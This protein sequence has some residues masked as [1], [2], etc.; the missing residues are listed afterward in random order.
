MA[1]SQLSLIIALLPSRNMQKMRQNEPL[2]AL[3][4]YATW[5]IWSKAWQCTPCSNTFSAL[6]HRIVQ[7]LSSY[8][9]SPRLVLSNPSRRIFYLFV[10]QQKHPS[11]NK[12]ILCLPVYQIFSLYLQHRSATTAVVRN[13][14]IEKVLLKLS[15][16]VKLR[17]F[18]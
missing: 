3:F 9:P 10:L 13:D 14:F 6:C 17:N 12:N 2:F 15:S 1:A 16:K 8:C 4:S 11:S 5:Q 18:D 7:A